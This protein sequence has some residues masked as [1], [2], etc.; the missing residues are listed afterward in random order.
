MLQRALSEC[1]YIGVRTALYLHL[2]FNLSLSIET[3]NITHLGH[4]EL[5]A[6]LDVD[7]SSDT[8]SIEYATAQ[9]VINSFSMSYMLIG[10]LY[11]VDTI[12]KR[13]STGEIT[14][15]E[16][17]IRKRGSIIIIKFRW[18]DERTWIFGCAARVFANAFIS[19]ICVLNG[20]KVMT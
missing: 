4:H 13:C 2:I 7:A 17:S 6:V 16:H 8:L 15:I 9:Y 20:R 19:T 12:D 10:C 5:L 1:V 18:N 14:I 3:L 11:V